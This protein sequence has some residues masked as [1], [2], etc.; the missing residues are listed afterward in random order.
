T[1]KDAAT[2]A[3]TVIKRVGD[4]PIKVGEVADVREEGK[5]PFGIY[6][7]DRNDEGVEGI[8][9]MRRGENPSEVLIKV[10]EAIDELNQT[11]RDD[12]VRVVPFYD[13]SFLVQSTLYTVG[14]S[15]LLGITLVVLVLLLFLG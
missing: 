11:L 3:A 8:V 12:G 15:V 4:Y 7:K 14:H 5:T 6:S 13:R 2:I 10:T 1:I 9:L